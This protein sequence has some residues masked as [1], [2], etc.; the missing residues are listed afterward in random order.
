MS[1]ST[2]DVPLQVSRETLI[3]L[4]LTTLQLLT[5]SNPTL[6]VVAADFP[7]WVKHL[8]PDRLILQQL[9]DGRVEVSVSVL[10]FDRDHYLT[11]VTVV[12]AVRDMELPPPT[13]PNRFRSLPVEEIGRLVAREGA[14]S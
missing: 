9:V 11:V 8:G 7:L 5:T 3:R 4:H 14:L 2:V 10:S 1:M 13:E 6:E 12:D